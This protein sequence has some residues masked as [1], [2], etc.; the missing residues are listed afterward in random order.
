VVRLEA[1]AAEVVIRDSQQ[2]LGPLEDFS[3]P[4]AAVVASMV[5]V[6]LVGLVTTVAAV[7]AADGILGLIMVEPL[8]VEAAAVLLMH[9][10]FLHLHHI[11]HR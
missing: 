7:V 5:A 3:L 8:V 10:D 11:Q 2:I 4:A 1:A 9:T 6:V